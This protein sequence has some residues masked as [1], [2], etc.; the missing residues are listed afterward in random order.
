M[1]IKTYLSMIVKYFARITIFDI[2]A[3]DLL[4]FYAEWWN[5]LNCFHKNEWTRMR[6]ESKEEKQEEKN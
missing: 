6:R 3:R 2:L 5:A 1:F 4:V